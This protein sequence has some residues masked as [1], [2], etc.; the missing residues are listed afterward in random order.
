MNEAVRGAWGSQEPLLPARMCGWPASLPL[1]ES[2]TL[3][4]K[5][6]DLED[7]GA[8]GRSD[9]A[10]RGAGRPGP[11]ASLW[12]QRIKSPLGPEQRCPRPHAG[13]LSQPA[14][15]M[16][17][18][19]Q[20]PPH[21]RT[22]KWLC[23]KFPL[24][25]TRS[26]ERG[27]WDSF[28]LSQ[29]L[30][31]RGHVRW[32]LLQS[33]ESIWVLCILGLMSGRGCVEAAGTVPA[34]R[35]GAPDTHASEDVGQGGQEPAGPSPLPGPGTKCVRF[36]VLRKILNRVPVSHG[37]THSRDLQTQGL[38]GR[39]GEGGR[40]RAGGQEPLGWFWTAC[41]CA[42][43]DVFSGEGQGVSSWQ[44]LGLGDQEREELW[45]GGGGWHSGVAGCRGALLAPQLPPYPV[46]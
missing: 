12:I 45:V 39:W 24:H 13:C 35:R 43:D 11:W 19:G 41:L 2:L 28:E 27:R 1:M 10:L 42:C 22:H 36:R 23:G 15:R 29:A 14:S 26:E 37:D 8:G 18:W 31:A 21:T 4:G 25:D 46:I 44:L 32:R 16:H 30:R 38:D 17:G 5:P 40:G 6:R 3:H 7:H 9:S 34:L 33:A 20:W